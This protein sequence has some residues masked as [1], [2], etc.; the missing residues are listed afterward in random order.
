MLWISEQHLV[1]K[2]SPMS[3]FEKRDV[4]HS[5]NLVIALFQYCL[6]LF[7]LE[8]RL[9]TK[10]NWV[11]AARAE[12]RCQA[13]V[14]G[15]HKHRQGLCDSSH[16]LKGQLVSILLLCCA[17]PQVEGAILASQELDIPLFPVTYRNCCCCVSFTL[18]N[19][20]EAIL[21]LAHTQQRE[22]DSVALGAFDTFFLAV[23]SS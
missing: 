7:M 23:L 6:L 12:M 8:E 5:G 1:S 14:C 17:I 21:A 20:Q 18:S 9:Y 3:Q 16:V 4:A 19:W 11:T 2:R 22:M 13:A 15:G 10:K